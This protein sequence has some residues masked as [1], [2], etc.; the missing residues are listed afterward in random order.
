MKKIALSLALLVTA[1]V[2]GCSDAR[3]G[4][5]TAWGD[6]ARVTCFSGGRIVFDDF[7]T[8]KV[9]DSEGSDGYYFVAK[10]TGR[11]TEVSGDCMLDYGAKPTSD[12]KP[13]RP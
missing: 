9:N 11:L 13:V 2:A 8:G 10:S 12:F 3:W 1:A 4:K 5:V 7:S 6:E